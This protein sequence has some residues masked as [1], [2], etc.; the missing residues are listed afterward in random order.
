MAQEGK[1]RGF[2]PNWTTHPGEHLEEYLEVRGWS[3]AEFAR[4][5]ELT[6]K[7]VS[8]IINEKNP[9]TAET[10]LKFERVL[11]LKADIWVRLQAS[12]DLFQARRKLENA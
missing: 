11:G 8:E 9:V 6:P 2:N 10:A 1:V 12:Y 5:A 7:L 4:R 3:Q